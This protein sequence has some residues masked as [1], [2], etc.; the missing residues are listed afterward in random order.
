MLKHVG[1]YLYRQ[2]GVRMANGRP[3]SVR[4]LQFAAGGIT[5]ANLYTMKRM[6]TIGVAADDRRPSRRIDDDTAS[7]SY[8]ARRKSLHVQPVRRRDSDQ[9]RPTVCVC[10]HTYTHL[11]QTPNIHWTTLK[12]RRKSAVRIQRQ[13]NERMGHKHIYVNW[14][15]FTIVDGHIIA[16]KKQ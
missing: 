9:Q 6:S 14:L 3:Q 1:I 12:L 5:F 7:G 11:V 4:K 10:A 15:G 16:A 2:K 13:L 8:G